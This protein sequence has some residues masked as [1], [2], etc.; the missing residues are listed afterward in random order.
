MTYKIVRP[1]KLMCHNIMKS[2]KSQKTC[3]YIYY[4]LQIVDLRQDSR[5]GK[6]KGPAQYK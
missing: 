4:R 6:Q 5:G 3:F 1:Q 2:T